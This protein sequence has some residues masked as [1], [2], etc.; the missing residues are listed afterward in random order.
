MKKLI[1]MLIAGIMFFLSCAH[2]ENLTED[3]R[4]KLRRAKQ[5]YDWGQ[6]GGP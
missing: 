2:Q 6:R 4:E 5:R 3:E 1:A